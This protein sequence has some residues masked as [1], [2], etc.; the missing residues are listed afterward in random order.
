MRFVKE[1]VHVLVE[2]LTTSYLSLSISVAMLVTLIGFADCTTPWRKCL[3][4]FSISCLHFLAA[5][6]I[7]LVFE[8]IL[9][10]ATTRGTL[11]REGANSFYNF[12]TDSVPDFSGLRNYDV[13]NLSYLYTDFMRICMTIFDGTYSISSWV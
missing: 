1:L 13:L 6:T 5:F 11:G 3:M 2:M 7:L 9:D 10:V 12:F 8:S 4:G